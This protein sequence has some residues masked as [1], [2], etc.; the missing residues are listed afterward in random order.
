MK[1]SAGFLSVLAIVIGLSPLI[2]AQYSGFFAANM[3]SIS[4]TSF[5]AAFVF[6]LAAEKGKWSKVA[7]VLLA[8]VCLAIILFYVIMSFIWPATP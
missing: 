4:I 6:I 2:L 3:F 1:K 7:S 8:T 5:I